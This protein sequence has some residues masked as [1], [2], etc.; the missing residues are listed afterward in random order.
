MAKQGAKHVKGLFFNSRTG[1]WEIRIKH[2][3]KDYEK[4]I[5]PDKREAELK[6]SQ[7]RNEIREAKLSGQGWTGFDKFKK[8]ERLKTFGEAAD[9]YLLER[10]NYKHSSIVSYKSILNAY[11][12]PTF[13]DIPLKGLDSPSLR[14]YQTRLSTL[15]T[16]QGKPLSPSRINTVMQLLRSILKQ[17]VDDGVIERDPSK[18][19][20]RLQESKSKIDP[21]SEE[22]LT[23]ALSAVSKNFRPFFVVQ[24]YTGARPNELQALR[25]SD[26]D[27]LNKRISITKGRV[28]G[29]E[30]L[31]KTASGDRIIPMLPQAESALR[32]LMAIKQASGVVKIDDSDH[33]FTTKAGNPID[34]HLDR[35]WAR[36]L[37]KAGLR[38]R[39]SYQLRHT[40][41]TH[42]IIHGRSLPYIAKVIGHSGIDTLVR[43]YAGWI[44][45]ETNQEEQ[46]LRDSFSQTQGPPAQSSAAS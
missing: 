1:N 4:V 44:D 29:Q 24:A 6:L 21:L 33:I 3:G 30:G 28:R 39:P 36:A 27:W 15:K 8:A 9:D 5:S 35:V 17:A 18:G 7:V 2:G 26:I 41:V 34:K 23:L 37:E 31:P 22:E 20:R 46:K 32:D 40:F 10:A 42:C 38:H 13:K 25:W 14:K 16:P 11:L 19:V 43:H 45:A 12:M